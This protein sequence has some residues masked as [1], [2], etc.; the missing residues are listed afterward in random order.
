MPE[1]TYSRPDVHDRHLTLDGIEAQL[2]FLQGE[3]LTLMDAS[4]SDREQ[5]KAVKD[6]VKQFFRS[7]IRWIGELSRSSTDEAGPNPH[8]NRDS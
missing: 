1:V 8:A 5:C 2:S 7:R 6:L 4:F 3:I